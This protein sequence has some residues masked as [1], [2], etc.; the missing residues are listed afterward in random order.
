MH[1]L[2]LLLTVFI[3]LETNTFAQENG[4]AVSYDKQIFQTIE[5]DFNDFLKKGGELFSLPFHSPSLQQKMLITAGVT[6]GLFLID[7]EVRKISRNNQN[8]LNNTLFNTDRYHGNEITFGLTALLYGAGLFT[9]KS[10]L[11]ETGF[12]AGTALFYTG[13]INLSL[14]ILIGRERP[15]RDQGELSFSPIAFDNDYNSLPSGH[16]S[17]AFAF[18][19]VMANSI[20]NIYWKAG[21]YTL[22]ASVAFSR[23]YHDQHWI[24]DTFL[25]A[26]IG[27]GIGKFVSEDDGTEYSKFK[28]YFSTTGVGFVYILN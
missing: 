6:A 23:I 17:I 16:A 24:S 3:I 18:S 12:K 19:T 11:R 20:D 7:E 25:G 1:K 13:L 21:W 14:K 4:N 15:Y 10:G 2:G 26:A 22:A 8:S 28:L 9:K 5:N 27:Y